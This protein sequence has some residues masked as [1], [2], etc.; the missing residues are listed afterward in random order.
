MTPQ[1]SK[2]LRANVSRQQAEIAFN[3]SGLRR[4][5]WIYDLQ[6]LR[7]IA[8]LYIPF[9]LYRV[10]IERGSTRDIRW[11]ALDL[12]FGGL[13]PFTFESLPAADDMNI[14]NNRN[15]LLPKLEDSTARSLLT[16]K[17]QRVLFQTGF[18]RMRGL[19][20]Q[21]EPAIEELHMPYWVGFFGAN[22]KASIKVL[23]ATRGVIE[24]EK[25]R[26]LVHEWLAS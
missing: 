21:L 10:S 9:R 13:D 8:D 11:M 24:G 20:I 12:V 25:F 14:V 16:T 7:S 17:I 22:E 5:S 19:N 4:L 18:F 3:S 1:S 2:V 15:R 23:D 26:R 6:P